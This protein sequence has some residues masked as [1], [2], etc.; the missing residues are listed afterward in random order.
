VT[1]Q[2]SNV[3]V[4]T[5]YRAALWAAREHGQSEHPHLI[6]CPDDELVRGWLSVTKA[7]ECRYSLS[8]TGRVVVP[9]N[10]SRISRIALTGTRACAFDTWAT[11]MHE[12]L[13]AA[14]Y[15]HGIAM[16]EASAL[17]LRR[18][19]PGVEIPDPVDRLPACALVVDWARAA[20][21]VHGMERQIGKMPPALDARSRRIRLWLPPC[22]TDLRGPVGPCYSGQLRQPYRGLHCL[23]FAWTSRWRT[24]HVHEARVIV[25][26][27]KN[28]ADRMGL[29]AEAFDDSSDAFLRAVQVASRHSPGEIL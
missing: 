27:M 6:D 19:F 26:A 20:R 23:Q 10:W 13:H 21:L 12:G 1:Y 17:A 22:N 28:D 9:H 15:N 7:R 4:A 18:E 3:D 29:H 11:V 2:L 8:A 25:R 16:Y 5:V 14:G 24:R